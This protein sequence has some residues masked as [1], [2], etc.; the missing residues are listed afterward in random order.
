VSLAALRRLLYRLASILGDINAASRGPAALAKRLSR[1]TLTKS[2]S[3]TI[4]KWTR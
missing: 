2:A 1:K 4:N 3:K